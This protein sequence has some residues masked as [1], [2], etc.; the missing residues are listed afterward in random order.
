MPVLNC[1]PS[2]NCPF[3]FQALKCQSY[4]GGDSDTLGHTNPRGQVHFQEREKKQAQHGW[5]LPG[6]WCLSVGDAFLGSRTWEMGK[7]GAWCWRITV[8]GVCFFFFFKIFFPFISP[9]HFIC[10]FIMLG[11]AGS[12]LLHAGFFYLR[13]VGS[14]SGCGVQASPWW[15][16][17]CRARVLRPRVSAAAAPRL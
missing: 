12:S 3:P 4:Q 1:S 15:L 10:L 13:R 7:R 17:W 11:C 6:N 2:N 9:Q 8:R 16:P 14:L 5:A